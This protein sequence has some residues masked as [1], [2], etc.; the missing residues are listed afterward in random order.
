MSVERTSFTRPI[1]APG[2]TRV[3]VVPGGPP[4]PVPV[5]G[6][7]LTEALV[8]VVYYPGAGTMV[9]DVIDLTGQF[10]ISA[11]GTISNN[12]G[13]DTSAGKLLLVIQDRS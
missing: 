8:G 10:T 1:T 9:T 7:K 12:G 4:G 6:I 5:P 3:A 11:D 2:Y 13:A